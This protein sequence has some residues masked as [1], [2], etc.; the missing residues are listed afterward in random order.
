[1]FPYLLLSAL[2]LPAVLTVVIDRQLRRPP[3]P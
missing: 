2:L 1:M 3:R